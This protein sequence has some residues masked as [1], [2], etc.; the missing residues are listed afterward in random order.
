MNY[1]ADPGVKG[2]LQLEGSA[3]GIQ[4]YAKTAL[5]WV[6]EAIRE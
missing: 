3:P 6:A 5:L 4:F 1:T 2:M